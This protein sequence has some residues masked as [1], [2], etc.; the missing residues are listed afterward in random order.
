MN[1]FNDWAKSE[2]ALAALADK[3]RKSKSNSIAAPAMPDFMTPLQYPN[4]LILGGANYYD[5]MHKDAKMPEFRKEN[6]IRCFS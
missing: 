5:H 1:L 6:A 3:L 2:A 4:K